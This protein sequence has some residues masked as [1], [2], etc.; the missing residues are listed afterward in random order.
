MAIF[1]AEMLANVVGGTIRCR[2]DR[3]CEECRKWRQRTDDAGHGT[4]P[5]T[6]AT[7]VVGV[8]IRRVQ[9]LRI[10]ATT[11]SAQKLAKAGGGVIRSKLER[12]CEKCRKWRPCVDG[13]A[14]YTRPLRF[15]S[16]NLTR[17]ASG[18]SPRNLSRR[19][20][21]KGCWRRDRSRLDRQCEEH[22]KWRYRDNGPGRDIARRT[23]PTLVVGVSRRRVRRQRTHPATSTAENFAGVAGAATIW[24]G[25]IVD[26]RSSASGVSASWHSHV[27]TLSR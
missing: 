16:L 3:R 13:T 23:R 25:G 9:P 10:R 2:L 21:R 5:P 26:T 24:S 11:F 4:A 6:R 20:A 22:R 1:S 18:D 12:R 19:D 14:S 7:F 8:T 15:R 27:H 17:S